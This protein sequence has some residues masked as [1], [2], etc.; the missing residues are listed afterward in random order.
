MEKEGK[1]RRTILG[2]LGIFEQG[3]Q[4]GKRRTRKQEKKAKEKGA[5]NEVGG[6]KRARL[7]GKHVIVISHSYR[8]YLKG[9]V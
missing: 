3:T 2:V 1:E 8:K 7:R 9:G 6:R 5:F 4:A